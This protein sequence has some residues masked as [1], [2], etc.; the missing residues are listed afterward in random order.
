MDEIIKLIETF[1][2][3][4]FD[5]LCEKLKEYVIIPFYFRKE[6]LKNVLD[7]FHQDPS[8]VMDT[9]IYSV[10]LRYY[11]IREQ[12][13]TDGTLFFDDIYRHLIEYTKEVD[14]GDYWSYFIDT[15]LYGLEDFDTTNR[16]DKIDEILND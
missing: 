12:S 2:E 11:K 5:L 16:D 4:E 9:P 1:N 7:N 3:D 13:L 10:T 8:G 15:I 6:D 14:V